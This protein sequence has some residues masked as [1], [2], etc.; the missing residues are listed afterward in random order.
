MVDVMDSLMA[1]HQVIMTIMVIVESEFELV[2]SKSLL[3]QVTEG[4]F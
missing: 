2:S 4:K 1:V 3:S